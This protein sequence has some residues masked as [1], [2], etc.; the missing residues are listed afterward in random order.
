MGFSNLGRPT[1]RNSNTLSSI[2]AKASATHTF[3]FWPFVT[4][5]LEEVE[6]GHKIIGIEKEETGLGNVTNMIRTWA[7]H[8]RIYKDYSMLQLCVLMKFT[9]AQQY[10]NV[11]VHFY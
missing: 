10:N 8:F 5:I 1:K 3:Y 2:F 11:L 4:L 7:V 6:R 9:Q